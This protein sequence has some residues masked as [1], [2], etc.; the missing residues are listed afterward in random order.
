MNE[1]EMCEN[2]GKNPATEPHPCPFDQEIEGNDDDVCTCCET[3]QE[4]CEIDV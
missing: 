4:D 3:C 2:C 1:T